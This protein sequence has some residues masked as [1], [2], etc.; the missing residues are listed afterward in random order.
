M[1]EPAATIDVYTSSSTL[2]TNKGTVAMCT[3]DHIS[4]GTFISAMSTDWTF[5]KPG[6]GHMWVTVVGSILTLQRNECLKQMEGDWILFIDD[7]MMWRPQAIGQLIR[8]WEEV[9]AQFEE[10]VIMGALCHR[11]AH[12]YDPTLYMRDQAISGRYRFLEMWDTDIVEVDATG[13]AFLL[14][15]KEALAAVTGAEW[16]NKETR[17]LYEPPYI[18]RWEQRLGEDL[19][20]CMDAKAAG[21][22]IFVDTRVKIGHVSEI[23]VSYKNFLESLAERSKDDEDM[24]RTINDKYGLKTMSS[25]EAKERLMKGDAYKTGTL[26]KNAKDVTKRIKKGGKR[27]DAGVAGK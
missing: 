20:F 23:Q 4:A 16:P 25:K 7:D 18:F 21:C 9:Q 3:R 13:L 12:P 6:E 27:K 2:A 24:V 5:L 11:R 26:G 10:P 22:R 14:I 1:S 15:P 19:R 8:S 17:M